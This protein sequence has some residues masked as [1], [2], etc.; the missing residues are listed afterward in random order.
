MNIEAENLDSLRKSVRE[1]QAENTVLEEKLKNKSISKSTVKMI[2]KQSH[3]NAS[4]T[5]ESETDLFREGENTM[6]QPKMSRGEKV[7]SI[8]AGIL[9]A[10]VFVSNL[11]C[12]IPFLMRPEDF[13][14]SYEV[15]GSNGAVAA[16]QGFGVAFAMW[17]V[18]YPFFI[19]RPRKDM[20]LGL[21]IILQQVVGLVGE[22]YIRHGLPQGLT[23][24]PSAITRFV[25]FDAGGLVLLL[26]GFVICFTGKQRKNVE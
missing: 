13:I 1:L 19:F 14:Q 7:R 17:N 6:K 26:A 12:I 21:V 24:L 11:C 25:W 3:E 22:L 16:I 2:S 10:A 5:T 15:C 8:L 20:T 23:S 18:T 4:R 9:Y